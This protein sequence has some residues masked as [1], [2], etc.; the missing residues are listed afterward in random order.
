MHILSHISGQLDVLSST[1]QLL[2]QRLSATESHVAMLL[3]ER[4]AKKQEGKQEEEDHH[5]RAQLHEE[6]E[7]EGTEEGT[8]E[9]SVDWEA[10]DGMYGG[11]D[12]DTYLS[13]ITKDV[14][15]KIRAQL[16]L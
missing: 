5:R 13:D 1:V 2:D 11:K 4:Q 15:Q 12:P 16:K 3:A 10:F 9:S 6:E 7:E 14:T 8:E